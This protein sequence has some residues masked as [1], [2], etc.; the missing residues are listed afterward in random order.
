MN[1]L[2]DYQHLSARGSLGTFPNVFSFQTLH[3]SYSNPSP[4]PPCFSS[5]TPGAA[6]S[7]G[8]ACCCFCRKQ[9][10][11]LWLSLSLFSGFL[12]RCYSL[13]EVFFNYA[14]IFQP[15]PENFP[16]FFLPTTYHFQH[17]ICFTASFPPLEASRKKAFLPFCQLP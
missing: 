2:V 12:L 15:N 17:I 8:S 11:L 10:S 6:L 16:L 1:L 5:A 13:R 3:L 7:Q 14:F 9:S 4:P